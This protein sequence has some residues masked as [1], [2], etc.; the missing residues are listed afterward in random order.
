MKF[1]G[2]I[3]ADLAG[4][5]TSRSGGVFGIGA[6]EITREEFTPNKALERI[7]RALEKLDIGA[8]INLWVGDQRI[9]ETPDGAPEPLAAILDY[10]WRDIAAAGEAAEDLSL[11][12]VHEDDDFHHTLTVEYFAAH[13]AGE[14]GLTVDD[15]ALVREFVREPGESD[16]D[17]AARLEDLWNDE[18]VGPAYEEALE[19]FLERLGHELGKELAFAN[20]EVYVE[21]A[22]A[23]PD[24]LGLPAPDPAQSAA[25]HGGYV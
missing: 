17:Y 7:A 12:L 9:F 11:T 13:E 5:S 1:A 8:A 3:L 18:E 21:Q 15:A 22:T 14:P 24:E 16:D 4:G 19:E 20:V 23:R 2:E 6:T 10:A 25:M